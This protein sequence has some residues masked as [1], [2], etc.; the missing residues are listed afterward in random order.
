MCLWI[1]PPPPLFFFS[2]QAL[3]FNRMLKG[4]S[5]GHNARVADA[6]ALAFASVLGRFALTH[7]ETVQRRRLLSGGEPGAALDGEGLASTQRGRVSVAVKKPPAKKD[8]TPAGA[9]PAPAGKKGAAKDKAG[10]VADAVTR[11][12]HPLMAAFEHD[13]SGN[14]VCPGNDA[15]MTLNLTH[16]G[17]G[18]AG[19]LALVSA[20][21]AAATAAATTTTSTTTTKRRLLLAQ[22]LDEENKAKNDNDGKFLRKLIVFPGCD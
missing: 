12:D 14:L 5:L 13:A 15:L 18:P 7:E 19:C 11:P 16:C 8:A 2:F 3:R 4:L 22:V 6:G 21:A 9:A 17:L 20:A 10:T 1:P